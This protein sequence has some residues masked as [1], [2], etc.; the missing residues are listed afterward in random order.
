MIRLTNPSSGMSPSVFCLGA[1]P[2]APKAFGIPDEFKQLRSASFSLIY[3][4]NQIN[5]ILSLQFWLQA[6]SYMVVQ[7]L[8]CLH[9]NWL[10]IDC[11]LRSEEVVTIESFV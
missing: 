4:V 11:Q 2:I 6:L 10:Y 1:L 8:V 7:L 5:K 9:T 3:H